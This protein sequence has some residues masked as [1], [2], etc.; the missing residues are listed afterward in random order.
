MAL[1]LGPEAAPFLEEIVAGEDVRL[2][3][4]AATVA[5]FLPAD[6]SRAVLQGAAAHPD[7]RVRVA[8]AAS[9]ERQPEVAEE[10]MGRLLTDPDL[11]V[12]KWTLRSLQVLAPVGYRDRVENLAATE[13]APF[14]RELARE[15][16]QQLP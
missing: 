15:V 2:A 8:A 5:A 10:L 1:Q 12:R 14:L 9:L 11:G 7:P 3:P 4:R 16:A 6:S 13:Q